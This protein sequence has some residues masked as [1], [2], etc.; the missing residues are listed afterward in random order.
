[1]G[2]LGAF[3]AVVTHA[4][5]IRLRLVGF[6]VG[7]ADGVDDGVA[8]TRQRRFADIGQAVDVGD[9]EARLGGTGQCCAAE[10]H[11]QREPQRQAIGRQADLLHRTPRDSAEDGAAPLA[12]ARYASRA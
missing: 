9:R 6:E 11:Q 2:Q 10:Q 8:V 12:R 7:A 1:V 5:Q 3:A 4:P